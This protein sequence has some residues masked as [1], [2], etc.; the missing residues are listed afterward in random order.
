MKSR[1]FITFLSAV[2]LFLCIAYQADAQTKVKRVKYNNT[3][4]CDPVSLMFGYFP[5]TYERALKNNNTVTCNFTYANYD[6]WNGFDICGSYRWYFIT[7]NKYKPNE[8]L[9]AGPTITAGYWGADKTYSDG[10]KSGIL[11]AVGVEAAY[12][13]IIDKGFTA[14]PI[15]RFNFPIKSTDT[16]PNIQN[17]KAVSLGIN[18]GYSW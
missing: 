14:E 5:I 3:I 12:K 7:T 9:S 2:I 4:T 6:G 1:V 11:F 16:P 8:G 18:L 15:F 10:N 17:F 13:L